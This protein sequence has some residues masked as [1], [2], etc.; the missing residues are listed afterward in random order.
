[1]SLYVELLSWVTVSWNGEGYHSKSNPILRQLLVYRN[2]RGLKYGHCGEND[3]RQPKNFSQIH[4]WWS[5]HFHWTLSFFPI[6]WVWE[7]FQ[8]S[9]IPRLLSDSQKRDR[10]TFRKTILAKVEKG[11]IQFVVK[12]VIEYGFIIFTMKR[13]N[14]RHN[15]SSLFTPTLKMFKAESKSTGKV[16]T[17]VFWDSEGVIM[18]N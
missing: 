15:G 7:R 18:V 16:M 2:N 9:C 8:Q 1:M 14:N 10:M 3:W 5:E 6:F 4:N 17:T 11:G 12:Y 13:N